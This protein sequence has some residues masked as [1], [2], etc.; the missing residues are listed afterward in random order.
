MLSLL[1]PAPVYDYRDARI[2]SWQA[3]LAD[4]LLTLSLCR[5]TFFFSLYV[6]V[7]N[8]IGVSDDR[9]KSLMAYFA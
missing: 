6:H 1:C 7:A 8:F 2:G 3:P 4:L 5:V 9:L